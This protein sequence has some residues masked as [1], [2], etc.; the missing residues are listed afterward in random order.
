MLFYIRTN[1]NNYCEFFLWWIFTGA[2]FAYHATPQ[3]CIYE[4]KVSFCVSVIGRKRCWER[5]VINE[6]VLCSQRS[7]T[8]IEHSASLQRLFYVC[9]EKLQPKQQVL[10]IKEP[11]CGS[12]MACRGRI[13]I[14][15]L[16]FSC[17]EKSGLR[18]TDVIGVDYGA[19]CATQSVDGAGFFHQAARP[20]PQRR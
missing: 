14:F 18:R 17:G 13:C 4:W 16:I 2:L 19:Q 20:N 10:Q 11:F 5:W 7:A 12:L 1:S 6:T 3:R 9:L 8:E 15:V